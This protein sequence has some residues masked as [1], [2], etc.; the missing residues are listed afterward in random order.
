MIGWIFLF[1]V[2]L[3]IAWL[4]TNSKATRGL[5]VGTV[6]VIAVLIGLY[7]FVIDSPE[8][9]EARV[10]PSTGQ[11]RQTQEEK[12]AAVQSRFLLRPEDIAVLKRKLVTGTEFYWDNEGNR[13][14]RPDLFSWTFSGELKNESNEHAAKD[15]TFEI[16]IFSCPV[17]FSTPVEAAQIDELR[18]N[19]NPAGDRNLTLYDFKLAPGQT[20]SFK[21][22]FKIN[23]Q[24]EPRN[25][26][27]WAAITGV[28]TQVE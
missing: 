4:F 10:P 18:R 14:E 2:A 9:R 23:N 8:R 24:R 25:W 1:V 20:K 28:V 3:V 26:H 19:C 16:R 12:R 15:V 22:D 13:I 7:F 5:A 6:I 17:F 11:D 27:Y 21:E